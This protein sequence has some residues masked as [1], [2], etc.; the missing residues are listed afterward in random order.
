[1]IKFRQLF[2]CCLLLLASNFPR[3]AIPAEDDVE[4]NRGLNSV[5]ARREALSNLK[6]ER[7]RAAAAVDNVSFVKASNRIVD[8][9]LKFFDLDAAL[10]D[11]TESLKV[12]RE[13]AANNSP[14]LADTL[15]L[16]ARVYIHRTESETAL[17]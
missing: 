7:T 5:Q 10:A 1:M 8:L 3:S 6:A 16:T 4:L 9:Q 17:P 2:F 14:L 15:T 12:A 11:T 13:L